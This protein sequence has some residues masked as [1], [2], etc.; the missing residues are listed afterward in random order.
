[1]WVDRIVKRI[2]DLVGCTLGLLLISPALALIALLI[3]LDSRGPVFFRQERVGKGGRT[4]SVYK[5]RTM[6][7][8][9]ESHHKKMIDEFMKKGSS[10]SNVASDGSPFFK[11]ADLDEMTRMGKLL[12]RTSLDELPQLL[13]VLRGEMSLVGPRPEPTYQAAY[14]K[15]WHY[16]RVAVKPGM[17][18]F[19][20]VFGRSTVNHDDMALM[21]IYY[22]QN[23]SLGLDLKILLKT[24]YIMISGKGAI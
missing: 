3:K 16:A 20:Q 21:D 19:W 17:T 24:P 7:S 8:N 4:F 18:G 23:W 10:D 5:F 15:P 2:I 6:K 22:I 1:V 9:T 14:Y 13:N 12:R 11:Y